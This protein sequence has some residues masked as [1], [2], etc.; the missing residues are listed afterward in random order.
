MTDFYKSFENKFRGSRNTIRRRLEVYLPFVLPLLEIYQN[1]LVLDLGC[2]RG[3]WL[4]LISE[5]GFCA[6]GVDLDEEMLADCRDLD[7]NVHLSEALAYLKSIPDKSQVIVSAFH[8]VEHVSFDDLRLIVNESLRV[9]KPAGILILE[10][11]N[12][13]NLFIG[14]SAFYL[15]PTHQRPIPSELL[16]FVS[17]FSGFKRSKILYLNEDPNM[18]NSQNLRLFNVLV[19]VSPD[20]SIVAQKDAQSETMHRFDPPFA[21]SMGVSLRSLAFNYDQYYSDLLGKMQVQIDTAINA[22]ADATARTQKAEG[23]L[24]VILNSLPWKLI[25]VPI[26]VLSYFKRLLFSRSG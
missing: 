26:S 6:T 17:D 10:T 15:D 9:L 20:Y 11:P 4:E 8:L 14:S 5:Y 1:A 12:T 18:Q 23:H 13:E 16:K 3:E 22:A 24:N 7:L 25:N 21:L 19:G 2:G